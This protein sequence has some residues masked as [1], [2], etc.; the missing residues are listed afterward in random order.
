V[1]IKA[2]LHVHTTA[3][4]DSLITPKDLVYYSKKHGLN[5]CAVTDH[6]VLDEAYKIAKE[7]DFLIIPGIEISSADGHI[8]ALNVYELIPRGLSAVETVEQ[9]H[10]A[11]GI[12]IACHP[13]V[14]FKG[15]LREA[16]CSSFDAIEVINA[17]A[18]PFKSSVKKAEEAAKRLGLSRVAGTDAHYGPQIGYGYTEIHAEE[19]TV[20]SITKAI[21]DGK[22]SAH[23]QPVPIY[24]N[25]Q[26]QVLR[27]R[28]MVR[29]FSHRDRL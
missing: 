13:Y 11:G 1:L 2:D 19:P 9:I 18:F 27:I 21:V 10:E 12:A 16:V 6:N 26:Q 4:K 22:C 7:T 14:Y 17:R 23:G 3:S 29:K 25:A 20:E 24:L 5:A 15:C 28:R 8:I